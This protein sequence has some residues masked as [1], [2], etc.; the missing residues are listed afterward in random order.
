MRAYRRF[1]RIFHHH[2]GGLE[3]TL[4]SVTSDGLKFNLRSIRSMSQHIAKD[5]DM[6]FEL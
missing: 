2:I 4:H 1:I 5:K 3:I 6:L